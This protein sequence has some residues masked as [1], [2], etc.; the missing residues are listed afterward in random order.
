[1]S[2]KFDFQNNSLLDK[3]ETISLKDIDSKTFFNRQDRKF[4]FQ[5]EFLPSVFSEMVDN[6]NILDF[7]NNKIFRYQTIYYDT[8]NFDFYIQHHNGKQSRNKVRSRYY[9][10]ANKTFFELKS[11]TNKSKTLKKRVFLK[12]GEDG[13]I[14]FKKE[15]D[16]EEI[17]EPLNSAINLLKKNLDISPEEL[18]PRIIIRYTRIT[19]LHKVNKEKI[20]FDFDLTVEP[21]EKSNKTSISP[22]GSLSLG[23]IVIA[24]TK[25]ERIQGQ[26]DF[27]KLMSKLHIRNTS[28][29]KYCTGLILTNPEIKHNRFKRK[30]NYIHKINGNDNGL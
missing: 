7:N 6:Y 22:S 28:I 15:M 26:S 25:Q 21:I 19:F 27:E 30:M 23:N 4:I 29:S 20:T 24:E 12:E 10:E 17:W 3:F 11:K 2:E 9:L 16:S 5:A 14:D 13:I 8:D 1:M 18:K